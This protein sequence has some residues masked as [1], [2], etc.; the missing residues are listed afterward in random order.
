MLRLS[1][2][3][4]SSILS[5]RKDSIPFIP[6]YDLQSH[7]TGSLELAAINRLDSAL[8]TA[9]NLGLKALRKNDGTRKPYERIE[10]AISLVWLACN[11]PEAFEMT[12]AIPMGGYRPKGSGGQ[13]KSEGAKSGYPD[14]LMDLPK[15]GFHG[16]RIE[17]K[18][19]CKSAKPSEEQE[20]WLTRLGGHGYHAVLCRGHMATINVMA[21]YLGVSKPYSG[22]LVPGWATQ[23]Y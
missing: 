20:E 13:I 18:R 19:F 12:T 14:F 8:I 1:E 23:T 2:D 3:Q 4:L 7:I 16:L 11:D 21:E 10:Q 6:S 15:N 22:N 9:L 5:K 17:I